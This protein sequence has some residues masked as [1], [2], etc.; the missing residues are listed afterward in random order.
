MKIN[1]DK[2]KIRD[3]EGP[4]FLYH[5]SLVSDIKNF[6]PLSHF[7]TIVAA[8]M[9]GT[10]QIYK[11]FGFD[12]PYPIP[13]QL[14]DFILKRLT[15][16]KKQPQIF[17]YKVHLGIKNPLTIP[18]LVDH[19]LNQYYQWFNGK[20][21]PKTKFLTHEELRG[22]MGS[23]NTEY[24]KKLTQFIFVDPFTRTIED[25]K[26]EL[27]AESIYPNNMDF[28]HTSSKFPYY[29]KPVIETAKKIPFKLAECVCFQ[30]LIRFMEKEGYDSFSY[31]NQCEDPGN[32]SYIIF[33]PQQVFFENA[34]EIEHIIP[35]SLEKKNLLNAIERAFFSL[36]KAPCD[37]VEKYRLLGH[38]LST[39]KN[40]E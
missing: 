7:G 3:E 32:K 39:L 6:L 13:K 23:E 1:L 21:V 37:R 11:Y 14:P 40:M 34:P 38:R 35:E 33:R 9:R 12:A 4:I 25:L 24:K 16:T 18:D 27:T 26:K 29:L 15:Q 30:R 8:Q 17:T 10:H 19:S 36:G 31:E 20:Y 5:S 2:T 28:D 22:G